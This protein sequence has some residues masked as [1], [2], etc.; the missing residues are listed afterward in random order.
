M[1]NI[2]GELNIVWRFWRLSSKAHICICVRKIG[3]MYFGNILHSRF[4][5]YGTWDCG[6]WDQHV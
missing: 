6:Y 2:S 5:Y 1:T 4:H 3:A